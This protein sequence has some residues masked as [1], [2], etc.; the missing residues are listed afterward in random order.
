MVL[1]RLLCVTMSPIRLV[2]E[3]HKTFHRSSFA[4]QAECDKVTFCVHVTAGLVALQT[5]THG[6]TVNKVKLLYQFHG[7][8]VTQTINVIRLTTRQCT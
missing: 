5:A 4:W 2:T 7:N 3:V 6:W 1:E 8:A